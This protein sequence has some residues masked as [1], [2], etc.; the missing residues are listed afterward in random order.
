MEYKTSGWLLS[1]DK[2]YL[3]FKDDFAAG[4]FKLIGSRD[5]HFYAPDEIKRIRVVR[6]ADGYYAQFCINVERKEEPIST[7]KA[8]GI[9]VGLNHFYTDSDGEIVAN[10][11]YLRKSEKALKRLQKRVSREEERLW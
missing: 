6:R 11:R 3:T 7:G 8:I 9:D 4:K 5:L 10:P 2:R 1:S